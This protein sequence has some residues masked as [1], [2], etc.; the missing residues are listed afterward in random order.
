MILSIKKNSIKMIKS[1]GLG[2]ELVVREVGIEKV[3]GILII[4]IVLNIG[5]VLVNLY[6]LHHAKK[7]KF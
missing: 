4:L 1:I 3:G 6:G 5:I 7:S 2:C